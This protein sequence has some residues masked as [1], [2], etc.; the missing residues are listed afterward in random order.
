MLEGQRQALETG[1]EPG[2]IGHL[3]ANMK[4]LHDNNLAILAQL[5]T[6][7][8][9]DV[10]TQIG[11]RRYFQ[12][13][14]ESWLAGKPDGRG[15]ALLY[16]GLDHFKS[17]NDRFGHEVGDELLQAVARQ[18]QQQLEAYQTGNEL[19]FTRLAG[20]EFAILLRGPAAETD[21]LALGQQLQQNHDNGTLVG[22]RRYA[23][24]LSLSL[25]HI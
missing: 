15:I 10:L 11:N 21:A 5:R 18:T 2:E 1:D 4:R 12:L 3:G 7:L 25:I 9:T 20:D 17:V 24:T 16:F 14:G 22:E 19:V 23:V 8:R 6:A 13:M